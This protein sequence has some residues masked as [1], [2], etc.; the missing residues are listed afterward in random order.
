MGKTKG[1][2]FLDYIA[3]FFSWTF[4]VVFVIPL[5]NLIYFKYRGQIEDFWFIF[6]EILLIPFFIIIT[7]RALGF[8][9]DLNV[10]DRR[11]RPRI[12]FA[13]LFFYLILTYQILTLNIPDLSTLVII[14]TVIFSIFTMVSLFWKISAHTSTITTTAV[15]LYY[16]VFPSIYFL[17]PAI[18]VITMVTWSRIY[19]KAH[20]WKQAIA[21]VLLG[22]F[23][24]V[25]FVL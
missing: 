3:I 13:I 20:T 17:I 1:R 6:F 21:G 23:S 14:Q 24:L 8:V 18:L 10:S 12:L 19:L 7:F 2:S 22:L 4:N 15:F 16:F 9:S 11:E 25:I 5:Q